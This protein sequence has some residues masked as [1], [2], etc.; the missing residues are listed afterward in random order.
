LRLGSV[1]RISKGGIGVV[2]LR[3]IKS[4]SWL[5]RVYPELARFENDT[6]R[7]NAQFL[8]GTD[9]QFTTTGWLIF[10]ATMLAPCLL[11]YLAIRLHVDPNYIYPIGLLFLITTAI[12][13]G[14]LTRSHI[15]RYLRG[16]LLRRGIP[17]CIN[18]AYDLTGN[19][20]GRCPECGK[21][22]KLSDWCT[23]PSGLAHKKNHSDHFPS[24]R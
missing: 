5:V 10:V 1:D 13:C 6:D 12:A 7:A 9:A 15:R 2:R 16:E 19:V 24:S 4:T 3:R 20:S 8:A 22:F 14:W 21:P 11:G 23:P 18:C 17:I